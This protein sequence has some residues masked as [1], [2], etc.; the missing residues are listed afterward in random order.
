MYLTFV[1]K[2][3]L[4][5]GAIVNGASEK[6]QGVVFMQTVI[7][8]TLEKCFPHRHDWNMIFCESD[9]TVSF[10]NFFLPRYFHEGHELMV[11]V[12][13]DTKRNEDLER[14]IHNRLN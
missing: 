7:A 12:H 10:D 9:S 8:N 1:T 2:F 3:I 4:D 13:F 14:F 6:K 11:Q 5:I